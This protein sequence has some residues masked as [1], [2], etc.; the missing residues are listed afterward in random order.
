MAAVA[1]NHTPLTYSAAACDSS[2]HTKGAT[3]QGGCGGQENTGRAA[4]G[5]RRQ[6]QIMAAV[7]SLKA[8]QHRSRFAKEPPSPVGAEGVSS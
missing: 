1:R 3:A 5:G 8:R 7:A 4:A 6:V 2:V